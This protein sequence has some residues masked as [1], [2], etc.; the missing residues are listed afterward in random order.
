[1][2]GA[3]YGQRVAPEALAMLV[4]HEKWKTG[5]SLAQIKQ[6]ASSIGLQ[7]RAVRCR[8]ENLSAIG[9]P[10]IAHCHEGHFIVVERIDSDHVWIADPRHGAARMS[11]SEFDSIY[12]GIYM[13]FDPVD[14]PSRA[15]TDARREYQ[16]FL[17]RDPWM[18]EIQSAFMREAG[19]LTL[20]LLP[21]CLMT[22]A[23]STAILHLIAQQLNWPPWIWVAAIGLILGFSMTRDALEDAMLFRRYKMIAG[24]IGDCC[25]AD[26]R[27]L[28]DDSCGY[29]IEER[30]K[31]LL[32]YIYDQRYSFCCALQAA[33]ALGAALL[34]TVIYRD[35]VGVIA[36]IILGAS[37]W[38][39]LLLHWDGVHPR[40][41]RVQQ[42]RLL[43]R[44]VNRYF[45]DCPIDDD[46]SREQPGRIYLTLADLRDPLLV[47]CQ[48]VPVGYL[49]GRFLNGHRL[50]DAIV[51]ASLIL[52]GYWWVR[53]RSNIWSLAVIRI[54]WQHLS[55]MRLRQLMSET[56]L[57]EDHTI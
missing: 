25:A 1:M 8:H 29:R 30:V 24:R 14:E 15:F 47:M 19:K 45:A 28:F 52:S 32:E 26:R 9:V 20:F 48:L 56:Q 46:I 12:S 2:I 51:L 41:S 54:C 49:F 6:I 43:E 7:A 5:M 35:W 13:V 17:R 31:W 55:F 23:G 21:F 34:F 4:P 18:V 38:I 37:A 39:E 22:I 3:H 50:L 53:V 44:I 42:R 16:R 40:E 57:G 33:I 36:T 27:Y 11:L 10:G